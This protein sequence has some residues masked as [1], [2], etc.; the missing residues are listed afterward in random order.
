MAE[1]I[2]LAHHGIK[3]QK[4]GVRRYQNP[5]GS[6]TPEGVKRY[7]STSSEAFKRDAR[8]ERIVRTAAKSG[9]ATGVLNGSLAA[10]GAAYC[11][12]AIPAATL[13]ANPALVAGYAVTVVGSSFVRAAIKGAAVGS[14]YAAMTTPE[15]LKR[16]R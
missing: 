2:Y 15:S 4:W 5:D 9:L 8:R 6:L 12:S 14:V 7:G 10:A 3:G 1:Y 16:S 13:A 11:L